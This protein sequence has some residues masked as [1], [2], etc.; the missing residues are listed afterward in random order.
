MEQLGSIQYFPLCIVSDFEQIK[1]FKEK[2][3]GLGWKR[4]RIIFIPQQAVTFLGKVLKIESANHPI[5][6][7][8]KAIRFGNTLMTVRENVMAQSQR[9][10][11]AGN[12]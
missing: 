12:K 6:D 5:I 11:E 1:K 2:S 10:C 9:V 4:H 7:I 8:N 3:N